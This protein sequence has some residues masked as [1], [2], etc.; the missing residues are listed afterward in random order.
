MHM[1]QERRLYQIGELPDLLQLDT[2]KIA[3]LVSTGQLRTIR[4]CGEVRIDSK[5]IGELLEVYDQI[6]KRKQDH[7]Q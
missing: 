3:H 2:D 1:H 4:I 6:S 5:Q 7:V